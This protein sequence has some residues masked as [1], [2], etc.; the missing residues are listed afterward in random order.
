MRALHEANRQSWNHATK[1]HNAHKADQASFL[2]LGGSTLFPEE[3]DLLGPVRGQQ[4]AHLLCNSGQDTLSLAARGARITGV[5]ISDEAIRFALELSAQSGLKAEFIRADVLEWLEATPARFDQVFS[6]YGV[7]GWL[8]DLGAWARGVHRVLRPGGH[9]V[10]V[11]FHP[12]IWSFDPEFRFIKDPYFAPGQVFTEPVQDYVAKSG[13]LLTPSG[14]VEGAV[15]ESNPHG[16]HSFQYTMGE[17]LTA[18]AEAGLI[19]EQLREYPYANGCKIIPTL[20]E[21]EG[22]R[23]YPP[24]GVALPPLM[25]GLK[26]RRPE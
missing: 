18:L 16:A 21:K 14:W 25:F 3:L 1:N 9:L 19:L 26:M 15:S 13:P 12:L 24:E 5:D 11:D 22:R 10:Y 6:S 23:L 17:L 20:V 4:V 7:V 2:R 8:A